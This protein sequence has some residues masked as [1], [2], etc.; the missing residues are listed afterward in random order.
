VSVILLGVSPTIDRL[1]DNLEPPG[2]VSSLPSLHRLI[3]VSCSPD[4]EG[5]PPNLSKILLLSNK[6]LY[7]WAKAGK[8]G[9]AKAKARELAPKIIRVNAVARPGMFATNRRTDKMNQEMLDPIVAG[10]PLGRIAAPIEFANI[11]LSLALDLSSFAIGV[12][13]DINGGMYIRA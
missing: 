7:S 13:M 4:P 9:L 6:S 1:K 10:I 11:F 5:G 3:D 12:I 8:L 2:S